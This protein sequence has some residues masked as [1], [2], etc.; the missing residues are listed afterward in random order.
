M[1]QTDFLSYAD[2]NTPRNTADIT[3]NV[4]KCHL[5]VNKKDEVILNIRK[6]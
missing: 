3:D 1:K 2:D 6:T 5:L 4:I